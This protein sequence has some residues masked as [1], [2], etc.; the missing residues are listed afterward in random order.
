MGQESQF[1]NFGKRPIAQVALDALLEEVRGGGYDPKRVH[2]MEEPLR[3]V[4]GA[5][6]ESV[7]TCLGSGAE[8]MHQA[9]FSLFWEVARKE[10]KCHFVVSCLADAATFSFLKRCEELGCVV[11]VVPVDRKGCLDCAALEACI[12]PRTA[13]VSLSYAEELTGVI[14]P[15]EA[16]AEICQRKR[17]RMHL[18]V[19]DAVGRVP[20][21]SA[22]WGVDYVTFSGSSLLAFENSGVLLTRLD[23]PC[24][25]WTFGNELDWPFC[26]ALSRAAQQ[27]LLFLDTVGLECARLRALFEKRLQE[28]IA[29]ATP[30][31]VEGPRLPTTSVVQF[32][33]VHQEMLLYRLQRHKVE[34]LLGGGARQTLSAL[35]RATGRSEG[36]AESAVA[37]SFSRYTVQREV[38]QLLELLPKIMQDLSPLTEDL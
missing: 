16:I 25:P 10:G 24:I 3:A 34:A 13:V 1:L 11:H 21:R 15:I 19:S 38:E 20:L 31:L 22:E 18:D 5:G 27:A 17:V 9:L 4:V 23:A 33:G 6:P 35:L 8:A 32:P 29:T 36:E 37:F 26:V 28:Q 30:L 12:N 14:Q 7:L 2:N